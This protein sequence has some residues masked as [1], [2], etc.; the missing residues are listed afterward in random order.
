MEF[1]REIANFLGAA[2]VFSI[3]YTVIDGRGAYLENVRRL[4]LFTPTQIVVKGRRGRLCVEGEGL[5]LGKYA[6]GDLVIRGTIVRVTREG[7]GEKL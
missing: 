3:R 6:A 2:D 7:G 1:L 4:A 5:S